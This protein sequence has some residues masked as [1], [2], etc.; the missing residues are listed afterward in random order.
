MSGSWPMGL[1][2]P[3]RHAG[4]RRASRFTRPNTASQHRDHNMS[5]PTPTSRVGFTPRKGN[6]FVGPRLSGRGP[7]GGPNLAAT[8]EP[9]FAAHSEAGREHRR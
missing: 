9:V 5:D 3:D 2:Y 1:R 6:W 7:L 4:H 8:D